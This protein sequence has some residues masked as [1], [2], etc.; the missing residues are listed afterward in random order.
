[1]IGV[2]LRRWEYLAPAT[3][4]SFSGGVESNRRVLQVLGVGSPTG[5]SHRDAER[6][7]R[8]KG[9]KCSA[10]RSATTWHTKTVHAKRTQLKPTL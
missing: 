4:H 7:P 8:V 3:A 1:M 10:S 5:A 6:R 9:C 2:T